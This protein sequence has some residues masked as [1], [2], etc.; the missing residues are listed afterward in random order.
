MNVT[1]L[2]NHI[3]IIIIGVMLKP[4]LERKTR[5]KDTTRKR[6]SKLSAKLNKLRKKQQS[7]SKTYII[8]CYPSFIHL[9][10]NLFIKNVRLFTFI[11]YI[12]IKAN[13]C[14][15]YLSIYSSISVLQIN[16]HNSAYHCYNTHNT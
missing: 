8:I 15:I 7:K 10:I 5:L 6:Y 2:L 12:H 14:I 11:Y 3:V 1:S 9:S 16:L 4:S 13:Q